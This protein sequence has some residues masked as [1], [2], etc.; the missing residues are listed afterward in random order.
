[1]QSH[2][3]NHAIH[4]VLQHVKVIFSSYTNLGLLAAVPCMRVHNVTGNKT[5]SPN[6]HKLVF[7]NVTYS[8]VSGLSYSTV[9]RT[10]WWEQVFVDTSTMCNCVMWSELYVASSDGYC[11]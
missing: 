2:Q 4:Y 11:V 1:M 7:L 6:L 3:S 9:S 5:I 8:S 10:D